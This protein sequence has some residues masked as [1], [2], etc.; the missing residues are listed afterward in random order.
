MARPPLVRTNIS[1]LRLA[2]QL[3]QGEFAKLLG[4]SVAA[5]QSLE[6]G[7]LRLADQLAGEIAGRTGINPRW[8]L[9]NQLDEEP[10]DMAGKP[11]TPDTFERLRNE[12][13][14]H[15]KKDDNVFDQRMLELAVQLSQ[16]R[17]QASLKRLYRARKDA[18]EALQLGRRIDQLLSLLMAEMDVKPDLNMMEEIRYAE[19]EAERKSQNVLRVMGVQAPPPAVTQPQLTQP[20]LPLGDSPPRAKG[21]ALV[22]AAWRK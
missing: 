21:M 12:I 8:L 15:L 18:T 1:R 19:H 13:P 9:D 20:A 6:I 17:N 14:H 22:G 4:R 3:N 5:V 7:R 10:Y 2:L 11:W 16:A